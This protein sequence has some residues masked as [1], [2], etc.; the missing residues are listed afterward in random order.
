[1]T[2]NALDKEYT[3]T[4]SI[5]KIRGLTQIIDVELEANSPFR[6]VKITP[7]DSASNAFRLTDQEDYEIS[8]VIESN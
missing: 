2:S 7:G 5:P 1:V 6:I 4:F 8:L 3:Y